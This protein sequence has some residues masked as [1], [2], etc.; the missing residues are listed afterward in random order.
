MSYFM[1]P[2]IHNKIENN[3]IKVLIGNNDV[4][5]SKS[6]HYYINPHG[7]FFNVFSS[8]KG[9]CCM[10]LCGNGTLMTKQS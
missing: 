10:L 8:I 9:S 3:N 4:V 5:I 6:L 2:T 1:M 7:I